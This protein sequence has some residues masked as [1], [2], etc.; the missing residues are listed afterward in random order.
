MIDPRIL[1]LA[2][3]L[4]AA[5]GFG[6]GW[7]TNGWRLTSAHNAERLE[8]AQVTLDATEK[9]HRAYQD[10]IARAGNAAA[11]RERSTQI[12]AGKIDAARQEYR[13]HAQANPLPADCVLDAGRLRQLDAARNAANATI[14]GG[15]GS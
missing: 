12:L 14:T 2:G 7:T 15:P 6:A 4:L 13:R 9:T 3:L 1:V 5:G 8:A 11:A 10:D